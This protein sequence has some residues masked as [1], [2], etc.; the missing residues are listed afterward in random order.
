MAMLPI[1]ELLRT[2]CGP[3]RAVRVARAVGQRVGSR[4]PQ[5]RNVRLQAVNRVDAHVPRGGNCYRRVLM[6]VLMD[7]DAARQPVMF[8]LQGGGG[9]RS[10]HAWL[11]DAE[12]ADAM[13][14]QYD[15]VFRL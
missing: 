4:A 7:R 11:A 15:A 3:N 13:A 8:G 6:H 12:D 10:G 5:T 9:H 2:C 1:A 14:A